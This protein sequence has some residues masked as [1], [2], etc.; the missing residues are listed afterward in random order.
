MNIDLG[1]V[2]KLAERVADERLCI[3]YA[4][5]YCSI[6]MIARLMIETLKAQNVIQLAATPPDKSKLSAE[7][8]LSNVAAHHS[9]AQ[10]NMFL[11]I[12]FSRAYIC[13]GNMRF[14]SASLPSCTTRMRSKFP[15]L[16]SNQ[17]YT[18]A[19]SSMQ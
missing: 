9:H 18:S 5:T 10:M 4:I 1:V 3:M 12:N 13:C 14:A 15:T 8:T 11:V 7:E 19:I 6:K 2:A 16:I 17:Q